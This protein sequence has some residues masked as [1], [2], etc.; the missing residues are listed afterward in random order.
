MPKFNNMNG[1]LFNKCMHNKKF[2]SLFEVE[3]FLR[4]TTNI[5]NAL[6]LAKNLNYCKNKKH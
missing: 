3:C 6:C 2:R 5:K 1:R 4:K